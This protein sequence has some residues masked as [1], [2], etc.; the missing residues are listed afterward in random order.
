MYVNKDKV[1]EALHWL[2]NPAIIDEAKIE[3]AEKA[4]CEALGLKEYADLF[5]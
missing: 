4:L 3:L 5:R 2:N 1:I